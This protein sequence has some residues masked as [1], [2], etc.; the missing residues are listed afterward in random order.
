[1]ISSTT[2]FTSLA[3]S[4]SPLVFVISFVPILIG[5]GINLLYFVS[6]ERICV[7]SKNSFESLSMCKMI[8]VPLSFLSCFFKVN[9]G[10]PSQ[11][12]CAAGSSLYDLVMISTFLATIKAE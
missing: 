10:D 9:S 7:S 4:P 3:S 1:M 11:V 6:K 8:S 5:M 2:S 12:Q